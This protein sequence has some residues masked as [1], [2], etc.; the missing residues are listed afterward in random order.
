MN[1]AGRTV[2][3]G[4]NFLCE[5]SRCPFFLNKF[6]GEGNLSKERTIFTSTYETQ[7]FGTVKCTTW[8]LCAFD[9][10]EEINNLFMRKSR[11]VANSFCGLC[12]KDWLMA[13]LYG[14]EP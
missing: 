1:A 10:T 4:M 9:V 12:H 14:K 7:S 11:A 5:N 6:K 13:G 2:F 3:R 8:M